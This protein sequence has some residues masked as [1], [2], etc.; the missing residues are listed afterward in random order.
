LLDELDDFGQSIPELLSVLEDRDSL[1]VGYNRSMAELYLRTA[2]TFR[3]AGRNREAKRRMA[4]AIAFNSG[5]LFGPRLFLKWLL[6]YGGGLGNWIL[7]LTHGKHRHVT[8]VH[9]S[10]HREGLK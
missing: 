4:Q 2:I 8:R 7:C 5:K 10:R 9:Q 6:F 3:I 1:I